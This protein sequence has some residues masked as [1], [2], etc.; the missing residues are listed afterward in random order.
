MGPSEDN[1]TRM[2]TYRISGARTTS[3]PSEIHT[4]SIRFTAPCQGGKLRNLF[5]DGTIVVRF[6]F[7]KNLVSYVHR[8][9]TIDF[10]HDGW[11][12]V[13]HGIPKI[14]QFQFDGINFRGRW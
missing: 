5:P 14:F 11:R 8:S 10:G 3:P 12:I 13:Q 2:A 4:S 7:G 6:D 1:R 9:V